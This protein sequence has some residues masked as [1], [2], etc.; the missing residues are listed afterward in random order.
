MDG[1]D[2]KWKEG[3]GQWVGGGQQL[4]AC[5]EGRG[6]LGGSVAYP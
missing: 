3:E 6:R 4:W 1:A 2:E 5:E